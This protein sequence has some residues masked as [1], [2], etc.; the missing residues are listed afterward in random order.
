MGRTFEAPERVDSLQ[1]ISQL[2]GCH[3]GCLENRRKGAGLDVAT[4]VRRDV[5]RNGAAAQEDVRTG[6]ADLDESGPQQ[7]TAK[8]V[9]PD[10]GELRLGGSLSGRDD[11]ALDADGVG[12]RGRNLLAFVPA[13]A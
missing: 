4:F 8:P 6:L 10:L 12:V 7:R 1:Q 3:P 5:Q 13:D 2:V 11:D 9:R